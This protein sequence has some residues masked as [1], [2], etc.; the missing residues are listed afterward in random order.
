[1][2]GNVANFSQ[3]SLDISLFNE[4]LLCSADVCVE[5]HLYTSKSPSAFIKITTSIHLVLSETIA[6]SFLYPMFNAHSVVLTTHPANPCC[7]GPPSSLYLAYIP[8]PSYSPHVP[9][10]LVLVHTHSWVHTSV[11]PV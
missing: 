1:M 11:T 10:V 2:G 4:G 5:I 6:S 3:Y 9:P 8:G 7:P